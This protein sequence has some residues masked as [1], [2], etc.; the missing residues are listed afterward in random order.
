MTTSLQNALLRDRGAYAALNS[1]AAVETCCTVI[2]L[3]RAFRHG[4]KKKKKKA[5]KK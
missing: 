4:K 1:K 5:P 2:C 3:R